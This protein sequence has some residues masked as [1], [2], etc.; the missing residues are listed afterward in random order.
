MARGINNVDPRVVVSNSRILRK[1][2]DAALTLQI[3]GVQNARRNSFVVAEDSGLRQQGVDQ[4][5]FAMINV[6]DDRD[7]ANR[8]L[9]GAHTGYSSGIVKNAT[10]ALRKAIST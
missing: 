9:L 8:L 5:R 4:G 2:G 7:I 6:G 1:N 10:T 3:V